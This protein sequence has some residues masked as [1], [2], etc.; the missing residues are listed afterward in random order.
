VSDTDTP[1]G[2]WGAFYARGADLS[3]FF[4]SLHYHEPLIR[5]L[6][7]GPHATTLEAGSGP[8]VMSAFLAMAGVQAIA[9]DNDPEVLEVARESASRWPV[10]P[11]FIEGDIFHLDQLGREVDVV[12]SQGVL[13]H[14]GDE[15]VREIVRESLAIAPRLVFSVPSKFY[16]VQDFGNERLM[17]AS[18]WARILSGLG[19]VR[20]EPYFLARR[21]TTRGL[22]KPLMV[23][24]VVERDGA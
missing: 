7:S 19:R 5:E 22:L 4:S 23:L 1:Q 13:E 15:E 11:E 16:G 14:F 9:V 24:G 3:G 21:R 20:T 17:E 2:G 6:L 18:D 10:Q 8:G 12:F